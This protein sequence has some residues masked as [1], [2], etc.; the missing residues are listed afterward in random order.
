MGILSQNKKDLHRQVARIEQII[1]K[2]L[3]HDAYLAARI[4]TSLCVQSIAIVS[5]LII[6]MTITT[7]VLASAGV[8]GGR[9]GVLA[10]SVS[11]NDEKTLKKG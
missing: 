4:C 9:R 8:F 10:P 7:I 2:V 5:V 3:D 6:S 1:K 11:P